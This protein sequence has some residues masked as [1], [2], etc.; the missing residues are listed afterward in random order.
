MKRPNP[1]DYYPK[2]FLRG[3][4]EDDLEKYIDYLKKGYFTNL[5]KKIKNTLSKL[6]SDL[7]KFA[8]FT[9]KSK[10]IMKNTI[11]I[12]EID[13]KIALIDAEEPREK[14]ILY[15]GEWMLIKE[16]TEIRLGKRPIPEKV[17]PILKN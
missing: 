3:K 10:Q 1:K 8:I 16:V 15:N 17:Y 12:S 4:Y 5:I 13:I 7:K 6:D 9:I 11:N 2:D 14:G